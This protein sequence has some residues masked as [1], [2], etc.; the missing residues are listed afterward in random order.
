MVSIL[1]AAKGEEEELKGEEGTNPYGPTMG[2]IN[3]YSAKS[4]F[5]ES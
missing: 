5:N 4:I 2:A 1:L 3:I